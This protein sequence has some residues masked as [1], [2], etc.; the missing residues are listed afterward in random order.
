M[1]RQENTLYV[2][3]ELSNIDNMDLEHVEIDVFYESEN[4]TE[5]AAQYDMP[6]I[7]NMAIEVINTQSKRIAELEEIAK[8][9]AHI[10]IDFGYGV[11]EI[12]TKHI[13]SARQYFLAKG[14]AE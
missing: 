3:N 11:Y 9:V 8:A 5:G 1:N 4:G 2:L 10:G 7:A 6:T 14:G 12:E 13:E